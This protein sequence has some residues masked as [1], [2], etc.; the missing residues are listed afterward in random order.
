MFIVNVSAIL[1]QP[2]RDMYELPTLGPRYMLFF[3]FLICS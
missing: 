3:F 2:A 1:A